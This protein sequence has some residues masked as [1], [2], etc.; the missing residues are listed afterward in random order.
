MCSDKITKF[1]SWKHFAMLGVD[2]W[3]AGNNALRHH[4]LRWVGRAQQKQKLNMF[5]QVSIPI[6]GNR[7]HCLQDLCVVNCCKPPEQR[8]NKKLMM[9]LL[10]NMTALMWL[11]ET[12]ATIHCNNEE[13]HIRGDLANWKYDPHAKVPFQPNMYNCGVHTLWHLK[14]I[15]KLGIVHESL[16]SAH[17]LQFTNDMVMIFW[18][19]SLN[20]AISGSEPCN[21]T[22]IGDIDVAARG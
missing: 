4:L 7:N 5:D 22:V 14:H 16:D 21:W 17:Q 11:A 8:K 6:N 19:G 15:I 18:V 20:E 13:V 3:L 2:Q 9:V 12:L 10:L 1:V